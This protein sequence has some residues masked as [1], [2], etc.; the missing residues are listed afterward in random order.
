MFQLFILRFVSLVLLFLGLVIYSS[1]SFESKTEKNLALGKKYSILPKPNYALTADAS[2]STSLTDGKYTRGYFWTQKSTVGWQRAKRVEIYL[3]LGTVYIIREVTFN[4]ARG[5]ASGGVSFPSH[6]E[7]FIGREDSTYFWAGDMVESGDEH[8]LGYSVRKFSLNGINASGRYVLLVIYP[9]GPFVFCDEVEVIEGAIERPVQHWIGIDS[10]R[11]LKEEIAKLDI[12]RACLNS[13]VEEM[14]PA[15]KTE[16]QESSKL[17]SLRK[18]VVIIQSLLEGDS[19]E[20]E[21]FAIH[22]AVLK[23][24]YGEGPLIVN[25]IDP[26]AKFGP[27]V[28][29]KSGQATDTHISTPLGGFGYSTLLLTNVC[30]PDLR[31]SLELEQTKTAKTALTLFEVP[32]VKTARLEYVADP[33]VPLKKNVVL[34]RGESKLVFLQSKGLSIGHKESVLNISTD[35]FKHPLKILED[36]Q[37]VSIPEILTLNSVNWAYLDFKLIESR[38]EAALSDLQAHHTNVVVV[39]PK[40]IP[41]PDSAGMPDFQQFQEYLKPMRGIRTVLTFLNFRGKSRATINSKFEFMDDGWKIGFRKWYAS[42]IRAAEEIGLSQNQI[43]LYPFDEM[44]GNEVDQ[45]ISFARWARSE[46]PGVKLYATIERPGSERALPYLDIAQVHDADNSLATSPSR[47]C[48]SWLY[49]TEGP[50]K[51]LSPY[52]YY[53]MQA[54]KAFAYGFKGIGFWAYADAGWGENPGTAWDDFDGAYPDY[55]VVYEGEGRNLI[56]S[57][58]WEAWR[59]G[60]E[61]YE[62]LTVFARKRGIEAARAL[63]LDVLRD[64]GVTTKADNAREIIYHSLSH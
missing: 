44:T 11:Q 12:Q 47:N 19:I 46:I 18:R 23:K 33:L 60:I 42:L 38:R 1:C 56:S 58:R 36:V 41:L 4:T 34:K 61:D 53:R 20:T 55:A 45:F 29:P 9:K 17:D 21:L 32:F 24:R 5:L 3:D 43:Y 15:V 26:W 39:P 14:R 49:A 13:M 57:R 48:E 7:T 25:R 27:M 28:I 51:S 37:E 8:E 10:V 40:V 16:Q 63:A 2:D 50:S 59:A 22:A 30:C 52:A 35:G 31:L 54:W 62:L 64:I 6:I